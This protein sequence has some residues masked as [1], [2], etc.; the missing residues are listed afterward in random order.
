MNPYCY[1][2]AFHTPFQTHFK[3]NRNGPTVCYLI[4]KSLILASGDAWFFGKFGK[5]EMTFQSTVNFPFTCTNM[6]AAPGPGCYTFQ[7]LSPFQTHFKMNRNGPTVCY[8]IS[9]QIQMAPYIKLATITK[10]HCIIKFNEMT[11]QS[12]VNF[13]FTCTNMPAAPGPGC[14]TFQFL[15]YLCLFIF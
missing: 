1:V 7:F 3:M 13:P 14:Y 4:S 2:I 8:L 5:N 9:F 6:P 10:C 15:Y 11:F 12:T